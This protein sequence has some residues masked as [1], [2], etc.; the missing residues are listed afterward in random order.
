MVSMPGGVA[1]AD[2]AFRPKG[3]T[4]NGGNIFFLQVAGCKSR[5]KVAPGAECLCIN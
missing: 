2:G 4:G 1:D 5:G 3:D